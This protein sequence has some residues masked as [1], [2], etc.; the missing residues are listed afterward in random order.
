VTTRHARALLLLS[1][2]LLCSCADP[3]AVYVGSDLPAPLAVADAAA[4]AAAGAPAPPLPD[5]SMPPAI[6]AAP[7]AQDA[8]GAAQDDAAPVAAPDAGAAQDAELPPPCADGSTDCDGDASN[9]CEADLSSSAEHCGACDQ[10]C[11]A[12]GPNVTAASCELGVCRL[13]CRNARTQGDCDGDPSNGCETDLFHDRDN[14]GSCG[15]SCSACLD[16]L[17]L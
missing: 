9:G 6:D 5:A 4:P 2:G 15:M 12:T 11:V 3:T 14:C 17:C 8:A 7:Q 10:P 1:A 13:T 16:S